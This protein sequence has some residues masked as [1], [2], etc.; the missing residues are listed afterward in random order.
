MTGFTTIAY[1]VR[2]RVAT[3]TLNR[4]ERLNAISS[5][6]PRE[7]R[8]AVEMAARDNG[9][10]VIVVTGAGR[11]FCAGYDLEQAAASPDRAA[12][13]QDVTEGPWDPMV[14]FAM[15][16]RNSQD[17]AALFSCHKPT[18][19][20]VRG[21]AVAGG[22]DIALSCDL[23]V[24]SED[25]KI[26]YPPAR[27]WGIPSTGWW[28]HRVGAQQAKRM[29]FTGDLIDGAEAVR[30]G[31][32][33]EAVPEAELD[34]RVEALARRIAGVPK[35]QLMMSKIV[36]NQAL[37]SQ[38]LHQSQVMSALFDGIAR[39]SPEGTWFK[40]LAEAEGF[41]AAVKAR[42]SGDPIAPGASKPFGRV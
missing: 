5:R 22:S 12:G 25:A 28:A 38:G 15:M 19:A 17:F 2:D 3:I 35:N 30:I 14:D 11:A 1:E 31:L 20:K 39:H 41:K 36:V 42:D 26:G 18:I 8:E 21:F 34:A 37:E 24:M 10:H 32:A 6:M 4:P 7:I 33:L 40:R 13:G 23:L 27:V 16:Y 29:L 9:V